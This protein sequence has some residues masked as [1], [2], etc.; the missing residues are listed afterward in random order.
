MGF[1]TRDQVVRGGGQRQR[2]TMDPTSKQIPKQPPYGKRNSMFKK[3]KPLNS[4]KEAGTS[5]MCSDQPM[6]LPTP[7]SSQSSTV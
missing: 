7:P 5:R 2:I 4:F 6:Y 1:R 3:M